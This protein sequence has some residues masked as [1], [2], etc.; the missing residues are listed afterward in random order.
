MDDTKLQ[1]ALNL[2][3]QE[4]SNYAPTVNTSCEKEVRI[5]N[6]EYNAKR[7]LEAIIRTSNEECTCNN[8]TTTE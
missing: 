8:T 7:L 2:I 1:N 6:M 4:I 3:N 5:L